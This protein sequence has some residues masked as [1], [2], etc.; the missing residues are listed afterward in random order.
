MSDHD[1]ADH[2]PS[3]GGGSFLRS[4][5]GIGLIVFLAVGAYLLMTEHRAHVIGFLPWLLLLA[6]PLM[7]L[8]M[9]HGHD[10]GGDP[11]RPE[12]ER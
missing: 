6:C 2:K 3:A 11:S 10:H 7:H 12:A 1:H 5:Y 9:H 8:F 4:R